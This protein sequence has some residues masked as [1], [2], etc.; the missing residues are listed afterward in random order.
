MKKPEPVTIRLK[1]AISPPPVDV[2]MSI[3]SPM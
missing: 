2:C 3:P 1:P